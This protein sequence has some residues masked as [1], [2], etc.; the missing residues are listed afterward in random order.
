MDNTFQY[1]LHCTYLG[2]DLY[3]RKVEFKTSFNHLILT[4]PPATLT[5]TAKLVR[6]LLMHCTTVLSALDTV[7]ELLFKPTTDQRPSPSLGVCHIK[8]NHFMINI[9]LCVLLFKCNVAYVELL[10]KMVPL[11]VYM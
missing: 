2:G 9:T 1:L 4:S 11:S 3:S 6:W 8:I 10:I 7:T 5:R